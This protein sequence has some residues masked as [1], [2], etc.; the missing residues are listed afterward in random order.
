MKAQLETFKKEYVCILQSFLTSSIEQANNMSFSLNSPS[1]FSTSSSHF[2]YF[3][4]YSNPSQVS[5][6]ASTGGSKHHSQSSDMAYHPSTHLYGGN[7]V[8]H[9]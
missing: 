8:I 1:A 5:N 3:S 4:A 7:K 9:L 2:S 6:L